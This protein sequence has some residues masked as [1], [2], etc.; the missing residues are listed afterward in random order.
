[1]QEPV[2]T[3]KGVHYLQAQASGIDFEAKQV[4]CTEVY[5]HREEVQPGSW[6]SQPKAELSIPY[7]KLV[8]ATGTKSNTFGVPGITSQEE[9]GGVSPSGTSRHNVFFLKQ[10]EHARAIRNRIIECFERAS[11]PSVSE[12]ERRRLLTFVVVGGGPTSIEFTSELYDFLTRDVSLWYPDLAESH[13][14]TLVEAGKHLLGSFDETLSTYVERKFKRR[15]I[16]LLTGESVKKVRGNSV[17]LSSGTVVNFGVCVWSTGNS[18]LDFI[19]QLRLEM[20]RWVGS[21]CTFVIMNDAPQ[22]Q[23]RILVGPRLE[24]SGREDVYALG[25]CAEDR[26]WLFIWDGKVETQVH[27]WGRGNALFE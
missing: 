25:D 7:D 26:W 22:R 4:H 11:S 17:E 10:L 23:G 24:V 27:S 5:A 16:R 9:A 2:R 21:D 20:S 18:P 1:M 3:I 14:V 13:S 12:A 19:K 8:I 15:Q 6:K